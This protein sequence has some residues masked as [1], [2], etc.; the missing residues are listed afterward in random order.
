[1]HRLGI[2]CFGGMQK[3]RIKIFFSETKKG[4]PKHHSSRP[5]H[6]NAFLRMY[7]FHFIFSEPHFILML[8]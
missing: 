5:H 4:M 1:M 8:L 3:A 7:F 2:A 6:V